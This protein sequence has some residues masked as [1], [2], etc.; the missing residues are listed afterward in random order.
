MVDKSAHRRE[1]R[2]LLSLHDLQCGGRSSVGAFGALRDILVGDTR[3]WHIRCWVAGVLQLWPPHTWW[4]I[5]HGMRVAQR[6]VY[7]IDV[8]VH[9][10]LDVVD[11]VLAN[12]LLVDAKPV[13]KS[14]R[15]AL[16]VDRPQDFH[17]DV[18]LAA[19][20][21]PYVSLVVLRRVHKPVDRVHHRCVELSPEHAVILQVWPRDLDDVEDENKVPLRALRGGGWRGAE[22]ALE[23]DLGSQGHGHDRR[24]RRLLV[25]KFLHFLRHFR[26]AA[27]EGLRG[28]RC[29]LAGVHGRLVPRKEVAAHELRVDHFPVPG[30]QEP[31]DALPDGALDHAGDG[32]AKHLV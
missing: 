31:I 23:G 18:A 6:Q 11:D 27:P 20:A 9:T 24:G 7:E 15:F 25:D 3:R 8:G 14:V 29:V 5:E 30:R 17:L 4:A 26:A 10:H 13:P 19:A 1:D 32:L 28:A 12:F 22:G 16:V 2:P 21:V